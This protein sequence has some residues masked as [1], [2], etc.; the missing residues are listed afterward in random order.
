MAEHDGSVNI[1][2]NLDYKNYESDLQKSKSD[3]EKWADELNN[4]LS[5]TPQGD[6]SGLSNELND[7]NLKAQITFNELEEN[8]KNIESYLSFDEPIE[9]LDEF[10]KAQEEVVA[11]TN[12]LNVA[13]SDAYDIL[14]QHV[15]EI[16]DYIEAVETLPSGTDEYKKAVQELSKLQN[17]LGAA[18][19]NVV[20]KQE[21]LARAQSS[22]VN[23]SRR[24]VTQIQSED[25]SYKNLIKSYDKVDAAL[26]SVAKSQSQSAQA[27]KDAG[28]NLLFVVESSRN[29]ESEL[30][31]V[32][33]RLAERQAYME[34]V[35]QHYKDNIN[36][37]EYLKSSE[38]TLND[39]IELQGDK[40]GILADS[41]DEAKE[42]YGQNSTEVAK[43][44]EEQHKAYKELNNYKDKTKEVNNAQQDSTSTIDKLTVAYGNLIAEG[45]KKAISALADFISSSIELAA[46]LETTEI[47]I[48]RIFGEQGAEKINR[49]AEEAQSAF[50]LSEASAKDFAAQI[51]RTVSQYTELD[52]KVRELSLSL[53]NGI[54]DWSAYLGVNPDKAVDLTT[55]AINGQYR[56]LTTLGVAINDT[57]IANSNYVKSL[58]ASWN[59]L[60]EYQKGLARINYV[61]ELMEE[62]T[63]AAADSQGTY[64]RSL[65]ELEQSLI[66]IKTTVARQFLPT[67]T[68]AFQTI[69]VYL[70]ENEELINDV[71]EALGNLI[72]FG[73]KL[74]GLLAKIPS[75]V[76]PVILVAGGLISV[77]TTISSLLPLLNTLFPASGKAIG[78]FGTAASSA[79]PIIIALAAAI[80]GLYLFVKEL[81]ALFGKP[82]SKDI[83]GDIEKN[84]N[85]LTNTVN[86]QTGWSSSVRTYATG[87]KN[88]SSGWALVGE[89]GPELINLRGGESILNAAKTASLLRSNT[90]AIAGSTSN[91]TYI[92]QRRQSIRS[93]DEFTA[94]SRA[95]SRTR[96]DGRVK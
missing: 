69:S 12:E 85:S 93:I 91:F 62:A 33:A 2:I 65:Y 4:E 30:T 21:N 61:L 25:T 23:E 26:L 27:S 22:S 55:A 78:A 44:T 13:L 83:T 45:I 14:N 56:S 87:T 29:L 53:L 6:F 74:I 5:I 84:V 24:I 76:Y 64:N 48:N 79:I 28:E 80:I 31:N 38:E 90:P 39:I 75:S 58:N 32:N 60:D 73:L 15:L 96:I 9:A 7:L 42:L 17:D 89:E 51:G 95:F 77:L 34:L 41:L 16:N 52:A 46:N 70:D 92:D 36:S 71:A 40:L 66:D 3:T 35:N 19:D 20:S 10:K 18:I 54:D 63:G 47:T 49:W 11:E 8:F 81:N 1:E 82:S 57:R 86:K 94:V 37:L 72:N 59:D 50:G 67:L 43:L 88:A 68:R